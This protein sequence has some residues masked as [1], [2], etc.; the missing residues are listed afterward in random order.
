MDPSDKNEQTEDTAVRGA[1][2]EIPTGKK[3][4]VEDWATEKG[5]L[6]QFSGGGTFAPPTPT[7]GATSVPVEGLGAILRSQRPRP[8]AKYFESGFAAARGFFGW[9]IGF[10]ITEAD[11]DAACDRAKNQP[12]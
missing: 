2:Q 4:T 11:F 9:P 7:P 3:R 12:I 6:P 5:Y 8:N 1:A 10:E